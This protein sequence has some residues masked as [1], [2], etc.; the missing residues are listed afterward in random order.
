MF[1]EEAFPV[2]IFDS[3]DAMDSYIKAD[4]YG[5]D[6]KPRICFGV[7]ITRFQS[8]SYEYHIRFNNTGGNDDVYDTLDIIPRTVQFVK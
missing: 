7:S 8:R 6:D 5:S 3:M 4:D 1:P 2:M